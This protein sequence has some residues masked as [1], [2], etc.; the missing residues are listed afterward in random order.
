V[1]RP[2]YHLIGRSSEAGR[3]HYVELYGSR[4]DNPTIR[5]AC[6]FYAPA[7]QITFG[8]ATCCHCKAKRA[9]CWGLP[10]RETRGAE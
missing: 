9:G 4:T 6:T 1:I 2:R 7:R 10:I 3:W 8:L 5:A